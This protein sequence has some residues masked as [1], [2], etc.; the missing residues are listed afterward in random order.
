M[1]LPSFLIIGAQ[2]SGTT[3]LYRD[4]LTQPGV[5]FPYI[6]EPT[7]LGDD[8]VLTSKGLAEYAAL[9]KS[10]KDSDI[11]GDASTGYARIPRFPGVPERAMRVLGP[12]I[13]LIYV[14]R[15][16]V[17]RVVSHHHHMLTNVD[18]SP[19]VDGFFRRNEHY[20]VE[21]T[22][23]AMQLRTWLEHYPLRSFRVMIFEEYTRQRREAVQD[24]APFLGFSPDVDAIDPKSRFNA[25][26][27][28]SRDI[29]LVMRLRR[30]AVYERV[31]PLLSPNTR[32]TLRKWL[33]PPAP[34]P[35][36][37]PSAQAV[38]HILE[39]LEPD[40]RDLAR[41]LDRPYPIWD[42]D[43]VRAKYEKLRSAGMPG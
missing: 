37:P 38:D 11:C 17:S 24:L 29:G 5:F 12:D 40:Q 41:L 42:P 3:T 16:P 1:K 25:A 10:A 31:R 21:I 27:D 4:L 15:E 30:T 32:D 33:A 19:T 2:K 23:Y 36:P 9:Y 7:C 26:T 6:K 43:D 22:Q 8:H 28:R 13:K 18:C 39:A 34:P 14:L 35:A 20:V